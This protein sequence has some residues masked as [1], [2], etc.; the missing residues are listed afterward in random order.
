MYN[1]YLY[2]AC[3]MDLNTIGLLIN[4]FTTSSENYN[5]NLKKKSLEFTKSKLR[6]AKLIK[7][8]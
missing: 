6:N 1:F 8:S 2:F 7:F 4:F 5:F 3:V